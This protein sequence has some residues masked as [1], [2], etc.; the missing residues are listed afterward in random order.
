MTEQP[1][2]PFPKPESYQPIVQRLKDMIERNNWK[3]KF[4]RAVHDAYK[5]GVEDMTNI[6]SLTDYYNFLNYFVLW[7]PK[8]DETGAFVYNML[9][10]MYFVLD[11]KTVR[12]FQ[13]PIKPSSYPPPPLTELSKWI[14]DFAGAMGQF[15]DT[16]QS[17]TEESLQ[18][19]YTAENYN[20]DAYVVPEGGWLGHSFNEFFARKFLPGTRPIDGPSN[21]AVIASPG[22][23]A[24]YLQTHAPVDGKVLEAKV[25]PGQTYLEVN[26][27]KH[28]DGKHR[29]IPTR[30]LVSPDSAGYQFCQT[31]GLIVIDSPKVGKVAVLPVGMAQVSSV[32]LSVKEGDEVK[33]GDELSYF[34]FGGSDIVLL[35]QAQSKVKILANEHKHYRVGEQIAI[36]HIAE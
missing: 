12:D 35:F 1:L 14:V 17:L 11:Q 30:G 26:I 10:T 20:V 32:V 6:S 9:G 15:L 18:T 13:S 21:P 5:T 27:K 3:D 36:A 7:V 24:S 29:L 25:I 23:L 4:E 19:F 8:E 2:G 28:S 34:Q 16:P 31:R 22:P 33:K